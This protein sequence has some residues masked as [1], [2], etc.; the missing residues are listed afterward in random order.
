MMFLAA[1]S[2]SCSMQDLHC[3]MRDLLL[4][5]T[6]SQVVACGS[7]VTAPG[8]GCPLA[9]GI[10]VPRP[11]IELMSS[12]FQG[13]FLTTGPLGKSPAIVYQLKLCYLIICLFICKC[14]L[15]FISLHYFHIRNYC[16]SVKLGTLII[17]KENPEISTQSLL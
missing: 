17:I 5:H 12:S 3:I 4:S 2:L 7:G 15:V 13:G 16:L 10:L 11:G 14:L 6:D 1:L 9:R 8:L